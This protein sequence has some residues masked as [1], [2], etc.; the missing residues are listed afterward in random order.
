LRDLDL[1]RANPAHLVVIRITIPG[2]EVHSLC[3]HL[4]AS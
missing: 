3:L 1:S 2:D 4:L